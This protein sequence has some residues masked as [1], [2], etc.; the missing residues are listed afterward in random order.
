MSLA[1][2]DHTALPASRRKWT[3]NPSQKKKI[4]HRPIGPLRGSS[5]PV[6]CRPLSRR[7]WNPIKLAYMDGRLSHQPAFLTNKGQYTVLVTGSQNSPFSS[8]PV[9]V[10]ISSTHFVYSWRDDQAELAWV[11]W[12]KTKTEYPRTATHLS[13]NPAQRRVTSLMCPETLPLS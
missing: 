3:L 1:I 6:E 9:A 11:A 13:T 7:G 8:L 5:F 12:L 2:W 10:I 4:P